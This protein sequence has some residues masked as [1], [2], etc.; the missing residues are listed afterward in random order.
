MTR[1]R[2]SLVAW[3]LVLATFAAAVL[4]PLVHALLHE[5]GGDGASVHACARHGVKLIV[6]PRL[7]EEAQSPQGDSELEHCPFCMQHVCHGLPPEIAAGDPLKATG[8]ALLPPLYLR[9]PR[10]LFA[11]LMPASR[12]PPVHSV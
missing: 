4:P 11:W 12:A 6:M 8:S 9:A 7:A 2:T 5:H 3:L 10:P 1:V